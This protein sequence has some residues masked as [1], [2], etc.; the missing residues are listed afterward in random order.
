M[1][2]LKCEKIDGN[3]YMMEISVSKDDFFKEIEK[4]YKKNVKNMNIPGFRK[5]KAPRFIIEK[6]YGNNIFWDDAINN[7]YPEAY[8]KAAKEAKLEVVG[9]EKIDVISVDIDNGFTFKVECIVAP[10]I[11]IGDYKEISVIKNIRFATKEDIDNE[12]EYIRNSYARTVD[13]TDRG[14][15]IG[16]DVLI[17]FEGKIDEIAFEGGKGEN[18]N[19]RLGSNRFIPGFEDQIVDHK[20]GDEFDI[21]VK[22]PQDYHEKKFAGKDAVFNITLHEIKQVELPDLDDE[23]IKDISEFDNVD[24]FKEDIK[25][26]INDYKDKQSDKEVENKLVD[27]L[28]ASMKG[29]IP[30]VMIERR[31][32]ELEKNFESNLNKQGMTLENYFKYTNNSL[33]DLRKS[34]EPEAQRN[35]KLRLILKKI[36][37]LENFEVSKEELDKAYE[38]MASMYKITVDKVRNIFDEDSVKEDIKVDKAIELVKNEAKIKEVIETENK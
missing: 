22:F 28:I 37:K 33:K 14:A 31:I 13:I 30:Q 21:K 11:E 36:A 8:M 20:V 16:D 12:I 27:H 35:V 15:K 38:D 9:T 4:V 25:K 29:E 1:G 3:K 32:D 7:L 18:Y 34:L 23:F 17:D 26:S 5:G 2:L 10:E 24:D 19:L 6:K